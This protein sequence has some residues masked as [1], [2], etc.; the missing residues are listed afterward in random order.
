[1]AAC[2][3]DASL[4]TGPPHRPRLRDPPRRHAEPLPRSRRHAHRCRIGN[5]LPI[6]EMQAPGRARW[7]GRRSEA[8][9]WMADRPVRLQP[10]RLCCSGDQ[11][12]RRA[13]RTRPGVITGCRTDSLGVWP[14]AGRGASLSDVVTQT[15]RCRCARAA[16][17]PA[18]LRATPRGAA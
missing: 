7:W 11:G 4:R 15:R 9:P 13:L 16:P 17:G 10:I 2:T 18:R 8:M 3:E 5:I 6:G 12:R 1:V 14:C